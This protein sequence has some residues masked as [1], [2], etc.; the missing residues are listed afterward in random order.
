MG[1]TKKFI[2]NTLIFLVIILLASSTYCIEIISTV[3]YSQHSVDA[4]NEALNNNGVELNSNPAFVSLFE[5]LRKQ[6]SEV[7]AEAVQGLLDLR[8]I[9]DSGSLKEFGDRI[10]IPRAKLMYGINELTATKWKELAESVQTLPSEVDVEQSKSQVIIGLKGE[11]N[12]AIISLMVKRPAQ[13]TL[14]QYEFIKKFI[15]A[16]PESS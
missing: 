4:L 6:E 12:K 10:Q 1:Q 5:V 14:E 9:L 11:V 15:T 3:V 8:T 2:K 16:L 7:L 13:S